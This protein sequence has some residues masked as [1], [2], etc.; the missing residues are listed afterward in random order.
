M[1]G[2]SALSFLSLTHGSSF[3]YLMA[4]S[5][6]APPHISRAKAFGNALAVAGAMLTNS[7]VLTLVARSD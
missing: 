2:T 7:V 5:K 1:F 4:T 6:V 3:K